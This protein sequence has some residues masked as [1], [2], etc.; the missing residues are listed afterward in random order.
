VTD[1]KHVELDGVAFAKVDAP[2]AITLIPLPHARPA[3]TPMHLYRRPSSGLLIYISSDDGTL[4]NDHMKLF[5]GPGPELREIQFDRPRD[6]APAWVTRYQAAEGTLDRPDGEHRL[7]AKRDR[8]R[9]PTWDGERLHELMLERFLIV[10]TETK[11]TLFLDPRHA[12]WDST[13][14]DLVFDDDAWNRLT[15]GV[16]AGPKTAHDV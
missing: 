16:H 2:P 6:G 1:V 15:A 4:R 7:A 10:E 13:S 9:M 11:V 12:N 8:R 3:R 5:V 14:T